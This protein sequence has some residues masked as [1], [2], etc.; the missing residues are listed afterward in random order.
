[1]QQ[2]QGPTKAT[3]PHAACD[4]RRHRSTNH[5]HSQQLFMVWYANI[6]IITLLSRP[7]GIK[8]CVDVQMCRCA[9]VQMLFVNRRSCRMRP[10]FLTARALIVVANQATSSYRIVHQARAT[11]KVCA[12]S[13]PST[14][15]PSGFRAALHTCSQ[16]G[17]RMLDKSCSE[18]SG[19][20][21]YSRKVGVGY[22]G[23]YGDDR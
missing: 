13:T 2:E 20:I 11:G 17:W 3:Y 21:R 16:C 15:V 4:A 5:R 14:P 12:R 7:C 6:Y 1:M 22:D 18:Q 23:C 8:K 19:I 9:D 10:S